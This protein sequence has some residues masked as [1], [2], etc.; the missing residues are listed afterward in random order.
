MESHNI[1]KFGMKY[2]KVHCSGYI[3]KI[4]SENV[5][6]ILYHCSKISDL[7]DLPFFNVVIS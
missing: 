3:F 4:L 7:F 5:L 2:W 1:W 6:V